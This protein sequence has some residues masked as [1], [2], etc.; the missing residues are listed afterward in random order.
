MGR[1]MGV[2]GRLLLAFAIVSSFA[3]V[4]AAAAM[5]AFSKSGDVL[6][7]ITEQRLPPA[8]VSLDLS[9]HAERTA[10]AAPALLAA[11]TQTERR[12]TAESL[13]RSVAVLDAMLEQLGHSAPNIANLAR[14]E[15][16]PLILGLE[17]NLQNIDFL[18]EQRIDVTAAKQQILERIGLASREIARPLSGAVDELRML[19]GRRVAETDVRGAPT[20]SVS[21]PSAERLAA[22]APQSDALALMRSVQDDARAVSA[23]T[24]AMDLS[25][26]LP[27]I[28]TEL[29]ELESMAPVLPPIVG[30]ALPATVLELQD[31][32]DGADGL[33]ALRT[34]ELEASDEAARLIEENAVVVDRLRDAVDRL[35]E[36]SKADIRRASAE[37]ID[38]QRISAGILIA[39]AV[40]SLVSSAL[41]TWLYVH[42]SLLARLTGL[43]DSMRA[44]AGGDLATTVP[45]SGGRDE[46]D[47]M[48]EALSVFRDTAV[49]VE[50]NNLREIAGARQRLVDA[51]ES[52]GEGFAFFDAEDRLELSNGR[53]RQL[54]HGG[55]VS[56]AEPGTSFEEIVRAAYEKGVIDVGDGDIE[57]FVNMRLDQH[58]S[59]GPPILQHRPDG[60]WIQIS[61]RRVTGGGTVAVYTDLTAL[62]QEEEKLAAANQAMNEVLVDLNSVLEHIEYGA[63][64]LDENLHVRY[65]NHAYRALWRIP[66]DFLHRE[67]R[68]SLEEL[69]AFNR[70]TGLYAVTEDEWD[71]WLD[72]RIA[73]VRQ[74]EIGP[75]EMARGDGRILQ[76]HCI[77][78]PGGG[79]MLTY[80]DITELKR[81]EQAL[82]REQERLAQTTERLRLALSMG[83]VGIWDVDLDEGRVWWSREYAAMLGHDPDTF[84]PTRTTWEE[85]LHPDCRE[86]LIRQVDDLLAGAENTLKATQRMICGNGRSIWIETKMRVQRDEAG[87]A[88][89]LSGLDVDITEQ[90]E[91]ERQLRDANRRISETAEEVAR[92]NQ[93]LEVLSTKLAK[94]LSPQVYDSIFS[95]RQ[96]VKIA[97]QR[98]KL[99]VFFSDIAGFTETTDKLESEELT[100]LLNQYLT[101]MSRIALSYGATVDKYVGD[102]IVIFFGDP[103]TKGTKEDAL[104][105]V[106]MAIEMQR[107]LTELVGL[108]RDRGIETP[109]Q[110]RIGIHTGYCTVGNFGGEDRMDYTIIG[111]AVNLASRLEQAARPGSIL[112]SYETY[113][114][115]KNE[116]LCESREKIH[117]RGIAYPVGTYEVV[118]LQ[119]EPG[120]VDK[121]INESFDGIAIDLDLDSLT[122][123]Q[124]L[125]TVEIL[126]R[127][128]DRLTV[129]H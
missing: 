113:A 124:R 92:K 14:V 50:E 106:H 40:L 76:Y 120:R 7:Q 38:V 72:A 122:P 66:E 71:R 42:R 47:R 74:G 55:D 30:D 103:E 116:V 128:L 73:A 101:E 6:Q 1:L 12:L 45:A 37:A 83:G 10:H 129:E 91:R 46:I 85:H 95:G 63:L 118:G 81:R 53:Y 29:L 65:G 115:V 125:T 8:L 99:T 109:L 33:A 9:R 75:V 126:R 127:T 15:V 13:A 26:L 97:S 114:F 93:E 58:R 67:P 98:K 117:A 107:R 94:Y 39:V 32:I 121:L 87:R 61:E 79:R 31:L 62:K 112:I 78:L 56:I 54:L 49:E 60:R 17:S 82:F 48:A 11:S 102:A 104:A 90:L 69:I 2:R 70:H 108:W 100:E 51:I 96:E 3:V 22:L 43:S 24:G 18:V 19:I 88:N 64:F 80:F 84:A 34:A 4:A 27:K 25:L 105:C 57:A 35:V 20:P 44:I 111:G 123:D 5:Y 59:P 89:R 77:V 68:P 119:G 23:A 16:G 110:A 41:I 86:S 28:Q 36:A 21:Q 52:I